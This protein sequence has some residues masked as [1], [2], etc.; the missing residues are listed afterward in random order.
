MV[1]YPPATGVYTLYAVAMI[2]IGML[3][4]T[5]NNV[6]MDSYGP[7]SDNANGIGEMSWH[8][9]TDEETKKG[10]Q[11]MAD[12]DA[13]GNTTKAIT[14]GVA[15]ASA[16]IAAVSL[17][18]SYIT[19]T[20]LTSISIS[21]TPVFVGLLLGGALPWLF[22]SLS[23]RAVSRAAKLIVEEVRRQ[24]RIPGVMEGK[25]V[26]D[27]RT[28]VTIST[29]AAQK[30]LLPL[31]AIAMT[32][33]VIVGLL[34][35][36]EA[37]GGFLAGII[38]SGQLLA[39]FMANSGGAWDN[40]KK[41]I[42]DEPRDLQANTGKGSERH[43]ASVVGDTVG[44]PLKDTAGPALNPMIKVVNL[45]SLIIAPLLVMLRS[46]WISW[47]VAVLLIIIAGWALRRSQHEISLEEQV[48]AQRPDML[49]RIK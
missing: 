22:S 31:A 43:K 45:I 38:V 11:I 17:F 5:G 2:G 7:I 39:V 18:A 10:R 46:S 9:M 25:V 15:I 33:P 24:F 1:L 4:H 20:G 21:T 44:D 32:V 8:D 6:A 27:Y 14:K 12:L 13:V 40:A 36:V 48:R 23:I 35:Q 34:L 28:V 3:S 42:E 47:V 16:V 26:P 41:T 37:L 49:E 29:A 19:S 30:E